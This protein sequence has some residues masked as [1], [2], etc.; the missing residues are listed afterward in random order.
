MTG[1]VG[2]G[3]G[4]VHDDNEITTMAVWG[5]DISGCMRQMAI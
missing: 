4:N 5:P 1:G 3:D 2:V